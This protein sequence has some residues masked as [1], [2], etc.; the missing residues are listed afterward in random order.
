MSSRPRPLFHDVP[1]TCS[2]RG[3]DVC[4]RPRGCGGRHRSLVAD[5][6]RRQSR[7]RPGSARAGPRSRSWCCAALATTAATA[8]SPRGI[9]RRPAGRYGSALLGRE[10]AL[11][12]DAAVNA[13]R[14]RE[15]GGASCAV[16][17]CPRWRS[18][19][20]RRAV[21]RRPEPA[22]PGAAPRAGQPHQR[23]NVSSAS[24]SMCRAGSPATVA[25]CWGERRRAALRR[26]GDVLPARSRR[27]CFIRAAIS[28]AM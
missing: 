16:G 28:A 22:V 19:G 17:R 4:R 21:W 20:D 26:Y 18:G 14:W 8:S 10:D 2:E 1:A 3:R 9:W 24:P 13:K 5:G 11:T 12:G 15:L 27:I 6:S 23:A 7:G 25:R